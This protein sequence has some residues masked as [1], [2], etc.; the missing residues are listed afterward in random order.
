[1]ESHEGRPTKVEGNPDHPASLGATDAFA[2]ASILTLYDPDRAQTVTRRGVISTWDAFITD[3]RS[4]FDAARSKGS[5]VRILTETVVSPTTGDLIRAVLSSFPGS[6]WHQYEPVHRDNSR[7]GSQQA[8]GKYVDP[9]YDFDN[10]DVILSLDS[11]FLDQAPGKLAYARAFAQRRRMQSGG[12]AMNRFYVLEATPTITGAMADH[13]IPA[14]SSD[15]ASLARDLAGAVINGNARGAAA[16]AWMESVLS[17]LRRRLGR[18]IVIAG[19]W[20]PPETHFLAHLLNESLGNVGKTVR[21]IA[22]V[23][24]NPIDQT[25]SLRE[26]VADM[27]KGQVEALIIAGANPVYQAPRDIPFKEALARVPLRVHHSLY[28]DETSAHTDWHIPASHYLEN[29]GDVTAFNGAVSIAQP[30]LMPLYQSK[31]PDEF[32]AAISG[33]SA[34]SSYEIVLQRWRSQHTG[35]DFD[36]Y[37]RNAVRTG[38]MPETQSPD[39]SVRVRRDAI[40]TQT[41]SAPAAANG[42]IEVLFRPDPTIFDGRWANNA[43]L[44]ELPKP[45][46]KLVWDNAALLNPETARVLGVKNEDVIA[47][48]VEGHAIEA[49]VL[50][51]GGH[52]PSAV[53]LHLGY[54]RTV[55]GEVGLKRGFDAYAVRAAAT[56]WMMAASGVRKV[57]RRYPLVVTQEHHR[58]EGRPIALHWTAAEYAQRFQQS[59]EAAQEKEESLYPPIPG[60]EYAWGMA[61]DLSACFGC[62]ACVIA[63]QAE[64]NIPTVGKS[65]AANSRE[66]HWIR[67]DTYFEGDL[68]N[69]SV[70]FEP[71]F[72]QHCEQ[73]PCELVCPVEATTHSDEGLNEMTYNRCVGTRYCSNNCPYKVRRFNFLQYTKWDIPQFKMLNNPDVT[74]RSRGVM[75]K[76]TYCV[77]R[78]NRARIDAKEGDRKVRDGDIVTACQAAC[79]AEAIT[80][81]NIKD[82]MSAVSMKKREARNYSVLGELNTR[83]RTTYLAKLTNPSR[84]FGGV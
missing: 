13:R 37:W 58:M 40:Q 62:N 51:V 15:I 38:V 32:F 53:T 12:P 49:P 18:S 44:Q 26:L 20:Q 16:P 2:Q 39:V 74:V 36:A 79:P 41:T 22:P 73:A 5:A 4:R 65:E 70:S 33:E 8:F 50:I 9:L 21:Y 81:G 71:M 77:Q 1:V 84:E 61:V 46:T 11:D 63:C 43:W 82:A 64:N 47:I 31:S 10:A 67:I 83:P 30:L 3:V 68:S 24:Q 60:D 17:D 27:D 19:E 25:A 72:C 6:R 59:T 69:P 55:I 48:S 57:G 29:W 34:R 28:F 7:A 78:I 80:F 75:E 54:G 23:E 35:P 56:P 14:R 76:C 66:M 42:G 52:A 45:L